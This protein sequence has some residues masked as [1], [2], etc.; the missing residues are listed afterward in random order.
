M[1][2]HEGVL[3]TYQILKIG[4]NWIRMKRDL[5]AWVAECR[6]CQHNKYDT[7]S[8]LRLLQLL[9]IPQQ[10]WTDIS[11]DFIYGLPSCKGKSVILVVVDGLSK[12]AHFIALGHPYTASMVAQEF[13]ENIFKLHGMPQ[14]IV[15]DRDTIFLSA[16]WREFFKLQGPKLCMRLGYHPQSDG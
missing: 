5:K 16:F 9:S 6:T 13:V 15:S 10:A 8:P 12:Y 4:F 14:T 3:K 7:I 1:A 11:M 2:G